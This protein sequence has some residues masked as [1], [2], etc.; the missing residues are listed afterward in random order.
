MKISISIVCVYYI[1][2]LKQC[3]AILDIMKKI[4]KEVNSND[5]PVKAEELKFCLEF[6]V[7]F[8]TLILIL[9]RFNLLY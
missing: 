7:N 3:Q 2:K 6:K 5:L 4:S 9:K 1:I 8:S